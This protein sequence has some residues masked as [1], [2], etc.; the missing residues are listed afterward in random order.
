MT[1][2][3]A[4]P[5]WWSAPQPHPA[6]SVTPASDLFVLSTLATLFFILGCFLLWLWLAWRRNQRL[7]AYHQLME[8]LE[9]D[10]GS[11][12]ARAISQPAESQ[13]EETE[14]SSAPWEK[15]ADWWK[16]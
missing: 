4:F 16:E 14:E 12:T 1:P 10:S 3:L 15:P 11:D 9:M 7:A 5:I 8:E 6:V 2:T 13:A